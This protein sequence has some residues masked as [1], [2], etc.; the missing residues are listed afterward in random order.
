M[1]YQSSI[2]LSELG[3]HWSPYQVPRLA[4]VG[5]NI[6]PAQYDNKSDW[7]TDIPWHRKVVPT[8]VFPCSFILERNNVRLICKVCG[9]RLHLLHENITTLSHSFTII[10]YALYIICTSHIYLLCNIK[11]LVLLILSIIQYIMNPNSFQNV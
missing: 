3:T 5:S 9:E 10:N 7:F 6:L 1:K 8:D 11:Q 2:I 4:I